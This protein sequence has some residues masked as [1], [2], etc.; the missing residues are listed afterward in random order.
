MSEPDNTPRRRPP[1]I[2][3]TAKELETEETAPP[4][5][6]TASG[7]AADRAASSESAPS[8]RVVPYATGIVAGAVVVAAIVAGLWFAGLLPPH[9][10][11]TPNAPTA[12]AGDE[13][14]S[15]LD[16]IQQALQTP[17]TDASLAAKVAAAEAHAK[18]LGDAQAALS[19]RVDEVAAAAQS[20][21]MQGKSASAAAEQAKS[22]AQGGLQDGDLD[23]LADRIA[24]LESTVKSLRADV[25]QHAA[26]ADNSAARAVVVAEALR[27]AVERGA[28][29]QPELAAAKSFGADQNASAALAPFAADGVPSAAALGRELSALIP[30]LEQATEPQ[31]KAG[32]FLGRLQSRAEKLVRVTPLG[33]NA[34]APAGDDPASLVAR[35]NIDAD[36]GDIAAAL[37]DIARLPEQARARAAVWI[38]KAQAREAALAASERIAADA[39][40]AIAKP[41]SQ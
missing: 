35:I 9:E 13:V 18:S 15:R 33:T 26:N 8:S 20:A 28:P 4:Q 29:Y 7:A 40:A 1:T 22:A 38:K 39:L 3:L 31:S 19:R 23:A 11:A 17:R 36:R 12:S 41:V 5:D 27:A 30:A 10:A 34:A 25:A 2:D 14:S 21:Q 16:R 32:S 6:S 37:A 24:A